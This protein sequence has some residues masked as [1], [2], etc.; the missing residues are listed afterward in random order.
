MDND[1]YFVHIQREGK[2]EFK[3]LTK[4]SYILDISEANQF[5]FTCGFLKKQSIK[6]LPNVE[7]TLNASRLHL[8]NF[9][10]TG[11]AVDLSKSDD[12]RAHEL[13]R[14]IVLSDI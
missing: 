6:P 14:R 3:E 9:W 5:D 12:P 4:H 10:K 11:G 7:K 1:T 13:E 8:Q 2:A